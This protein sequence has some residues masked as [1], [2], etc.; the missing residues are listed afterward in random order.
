MVDI[1]IICIHFPRQYHLNQSHV[2][3][4]IAVRSQWLLNGQQIS[5]EYELGASCKW[6]SS[7]REIWGERCQRHMSQN[8]TNEVALEPD[9]E[10]YYGE[11]YSQS[12]KICPGHFHVDHQGSV[13]R[14]RRTFFEWKQPQQRPEEGF[15]RTEAPQFMMELCLQQN[16][17]R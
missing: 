6:G 3:Y 7:V 4:S 15:T 2:K 5:S 12:N 10:K 9:L 11:Q 8:L 17:C 16:H 1:F 13:E 14:R